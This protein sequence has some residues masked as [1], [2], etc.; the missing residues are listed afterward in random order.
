MALAAQPAPGNT[1][2]NNLEDQLSIPTGALGTSFNGDPSQF[3]ANKRDCP[4]DLRPRLAQRI[5]EVPRNVFDYVWVFGFAPA[6]LPRYDGLRPLYSD[7]AS[8][9]Y[10]VER[11]KG[12]H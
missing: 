6:S 3:V 11:K 9:L 4:A 1:Y 5:A 8:V 12:R 2:W 7:G 10:A